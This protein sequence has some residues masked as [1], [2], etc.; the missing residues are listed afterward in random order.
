MRSAARRL[1]RATDT[2]DGRADS[3][4]RRA[5]NA[6]DDTAAAPTKAGEPMATVGGVRGSAKG[7]AGETGKTERVRAGDGHQR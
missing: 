5:T 3:A 6:V 7:A 1:T 2:A 4:D